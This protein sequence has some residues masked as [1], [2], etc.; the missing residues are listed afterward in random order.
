MGYKTDAADCD[1][2]KRH[3]PGIAATPVARK[4]ARENGIILACIT[5]T[6]MAGQVK[7]QDVLQAVGR[8]RNAAGIAVPPSIGM[9]QARADVGALLEI[10][11]EITRQAGIE[12]PL[13]VFVLQAV[14]AVFRQEVAN[15]GRD[16][17]VGVI[18]PA[19]DGKKRPM[20]VIGN[21]DKLSL[22]K[23]TGL[24]EDLQTGR[25]DGQPFPTV[26]KAPVF[27]VCDLSSF[28][29]TGLAPEVCA[30]SSAALGIGMVEEIAQGTA[31][32]KKMLCLSLGFDRGK[33]DDTQ[34]ARFL[35]GVAHRLQE[36]LY[37][38]ISY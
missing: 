23:I 25:A 7:K 19:R 1:R 13:S 30:G 4:L 29:I 20:R 3:R 37:S 33:M 9:L 5:P 8:Q 32:Y 16:L 26:R 35:C 27:T 2:K 18:L 11:A 21:L 36:P 15:S 12:I 28:E 31:G 6:G 22:G 14:A 38:L 10:S 34:A 17:D 24:V